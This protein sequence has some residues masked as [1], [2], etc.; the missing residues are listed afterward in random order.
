MGQ[1]FSSGFFVVSQINNKV[2]FKGIVGERG[3]RSSILALDSFQPVKKACL[4][5]KKGVDVFHGL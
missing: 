1:T 3:G 2:C 4:S 5:S